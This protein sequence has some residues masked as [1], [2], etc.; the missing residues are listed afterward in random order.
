[1]LQALSFQVSDHRSPKLV[2][3]STVLHQ[4]EG[5][6]AIIGYRLISTVMGQWVY[7]L[8]LEKKQVNSATKPH[9]TQVQSTTKP[10]G[11]EGCMSPCMCCI[12]TAIPLPIN[13]ANRQSSFTSAQVSVEM[14]LVWLQKIIST[15]PLL[16]LPVSITYMLM[17]MLGLKKISIDHF[18]QQW[19]NY[20]F[21]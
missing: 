14:T 21:D 8:C 9:P 6:K 2:F 18:S 1:M 16:T 10:D 3:E 17:Y 7:Q 13:A 20:N 19:Q 12:I 4:A 11:L 5:K 15:H